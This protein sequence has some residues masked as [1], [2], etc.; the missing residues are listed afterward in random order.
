MKVTSVSPSIG[1]FYG[2][3]LITIKGINFVN[4]ALQTMVTIGDQLNQLCRIESI[5]ATEIKCRTPPKHADD[6]TGTKLEVEVM[7]QL[8]IET[9]CSIGEYC[10]F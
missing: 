10:W 6:A 4:D 1:S 3:T 8:I 9:N 5:T 7:S 2:G